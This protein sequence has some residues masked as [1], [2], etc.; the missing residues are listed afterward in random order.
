MICQER[1]YPV[2]LL[3]VL[4]GEKARHSGSTDRAGSLG[5]STALIGYGHSS[6]GDVPR[7]ATLYAIGIKFHE[8]PPQSRYSN[9]NCTKR[10]RVV[11]SIFWIADREIPHPQAYFT[12]LTKNEQTRGEALRRHFICQ[13]LTSICPSGAEAGS[14]V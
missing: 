7:L 8:N 10:W 14:D 13:A 3:L 11:L 5:H 9:V 4:G 2:E 6:F 1:V 12:T